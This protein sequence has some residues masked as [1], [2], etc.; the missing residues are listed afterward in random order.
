[1][2]LSILIP[3]YN[4]AER[5]RS[6]LD[7]YGNA[8][9][10]LNAE[11]LVIVNGSNDQTE[12][13]IR[14]EYL[15]RYSKIRLVVIPEKVGK[16]GALMRGISES[17]GKKIAFTDADGST[18]P[19]A[20]WALVAK[21][22]RPGIVLGSRWMPDSI[23][24][25]K[26]PLSRRVMS[27]IFN[28]YVRLLFGLNVTDTQCGAK[29]ISREVLTAII[30]AVG[31]TQWA[32]DVEVLFQIRRAGYPLREFPTEWNDVSGS[33]VKIFRS[34]IEMTFALIRLRCIYSPLKPLVT[35]W[36]RSLGRKLFDRRMARMRSIYAQNT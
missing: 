8:V 10:N 24:G 17:S 15:P 29:V 11:I 27:R 5:I 33:K 1:M 20:L 16:G 14:E 12:S 6:T 19:E 34:S 7:S 2:D 32:F 26:Q 18:P 21:L 36:D 22:D 3:A 25:R 35:L 28:F 30:P 31:T 4:E 23:I 13:L 9:E